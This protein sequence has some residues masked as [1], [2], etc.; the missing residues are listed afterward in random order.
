SEASLHV[1]DVD[2]HPVLWLSLLPHR[3]TDRSTLQGDFALRLLHCADGRNP[4]CESGGDLPRQRVR[5]RRTAV[6]HPVDPRVRA[7]GDLLARGEGRAQYRQG[8]EEDPRGL[9]DFLAITPL[10][11]TH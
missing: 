4:R 1:G 8:K 5:E 7:T 10:S 2:V 11:A 3:E 6:P 9:Q